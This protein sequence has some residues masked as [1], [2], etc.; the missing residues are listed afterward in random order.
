MNLSLVFRASAAVL[1]LNGLMALF[2]TDQFMSM[3]DFDV[4]T[5]MHT[6]GQFMGVTFLIFG[7]IAWKTVDLA[8]D[9]LAAF[10]KVYA[11][12]EA[13]W[14]GIIAFHVATGAA[15]G[16]TALL[17]PWHQQP[18]GHPVLHAEPRLTPSCDSRIP[19]RGSV[20]C[21]FSCATSAII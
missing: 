16:A 8:G 15:G 5:D 10:G 14:V 18:A 19:K 7:L 21:P 2:M 4:T 13:M 6:L 1:F 11:L 9:N 20:G 3:A 17:Q 12:A